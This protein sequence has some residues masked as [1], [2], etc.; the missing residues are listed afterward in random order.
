MTAENYYTYD[1]FISE[2]ES[3]ALGQWIL[4][5][6]QNNNFKKAG[7]PGTIRKTTRFSKSIEYP[8]Q[9]YT[10]QKRIDALITELFKLDMIVRVP[11]FPDGM[12]GSYGFKGDACQIHTDPRW[13]KNYITYHFNIMLSTYQNGD[14][15]VN[16]NLVKLKKTDAVLYPVSELP[17]YTTELTGSEPRL[18]WCFGYCVPLHKTKFSV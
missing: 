8:D 12:Y 16:H 9:A 7:H 15:Y 3:E 13:I 17:H 11:D 4:D 5:N 18:F 10:I 14:L 1:D 2:S 6:Y